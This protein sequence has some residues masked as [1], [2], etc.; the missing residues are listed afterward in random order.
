MS[1]ASP[2]NPQSDF[3]ADEEIFAAE[4]VLEA[5][6]GELQRVKRQPKKKTTKR[7][8]SVASCSSKLRPPGWSAR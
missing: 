4:E 8:V 6:D 2:Q 5:E 7:N 3:P 1:T